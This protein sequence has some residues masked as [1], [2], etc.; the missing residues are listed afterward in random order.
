MKKV[1]IGVGIGCG[2]LVLLAVIAVVVGALWVKGKVE[3]AVEQAEV[4]EAQ[5]EQISAL[6]AKYAFKAPAEGKPLRLEEGRLKEYLAVRAA[7]MPVFR[8]FEAKANAFEKKNQGTQSLGAG[9][10]AM[11]M[12][13]GLIRDVRAR[14]VEELE[15]QKMSPTEF[16]T[17]TGTIY[18][19]HIGKGMAE[20]HQ[21]HREVLGKATEELE[22]RLADDSLSGDERVLLEQQL[23]A[24]RQQADAMPSREVPREE[25]AV[26]E[27]NLALLEKYKVQIENE[28]NPAL[29]LF[30]FGENSGLENAFKPLECFGRGE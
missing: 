16:H 11:G 27:A 12:V 4:L 18:S 30:L 20:V 22:R 29:D 24:V 25:L 3:G 15:R 6:E 23:E 2:G 28:A 17:I 19:S 5:S 10:E 26:Y 1:L 14:Y 21:G 8:A 9:L 7:V 13:A